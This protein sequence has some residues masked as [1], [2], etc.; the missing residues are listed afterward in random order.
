M[1]VAYLA[2]S[3]NKGHFLLKQAFTEFS[4]IAAVN[5]TTQVSRLNQK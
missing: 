5:L 2:S 1:T 3:N 4:D